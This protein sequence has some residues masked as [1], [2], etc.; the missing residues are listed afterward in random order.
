MDDPKLYSSSIQKG[1]LQLAIITEFSRDMGMTFGENKCGYLY[2][3][4][5]K[6]KV[7]DNR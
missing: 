4:H 6:R 7:K 3:E 5:G 2:I 1:K